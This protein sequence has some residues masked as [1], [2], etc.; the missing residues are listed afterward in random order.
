M[1]LTGP[2]TDDAKATGAGRRRSIPVGDLLFRYALVLAWLAIIAIFGLLRPDTFLTSANFKTIF[3]SQAVLLIVALALTVAL[4]SGEFD[5]SIGGTLGLSLVLVGWLNVDQGWAIIPAIVAA[6][7]AGI[8]VGLV[9]AFFIVVVDVDSIVVTL[10]MGTLLSGV[11]VG[12][13]NATVSGISHSLVHAARNEFL[14]VQH[15]F[16]FGL[17]LTA[18]I[19]YVYSYTPLGRHLYFVGAGRDVARLSGLRVDAIRIGSLVFSGFV[20]ALAGVVLAGTLGAAD[21]SV[22]PSYLLPAFAAAFLG[23]TAISPGRFNPWGT[24][25]AVYFLVTGITGLQ[26]LGLVGWI[27]QFFYG[28]SLVLA[29]TFSRLVGRRRAS[30]LASD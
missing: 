26:L 15:A 3:G 11:A 9:N 8:A 1:S 28:A 13:N 17:I 2:A 10:G 22:G 18:V 30:S 5:L 7:A 24:F 29:V 12:V 14:G 6:L 20:A 21:P 27:E 16:W 4:T 23:S 25:V 19:W